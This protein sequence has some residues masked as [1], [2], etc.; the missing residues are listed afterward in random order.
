MAIVD[1]KYLK[2][3]FEFQ[4][5][6]KS[7]NTNNFME[8]YKEYLNFNKGDSVE[9]Y[10]MSGNR[11]YCPLKDTS[12]NKKVKNILIIVHELSRTGAP[13]VAL[14]TAKVLKTEGY[15][16][17][18]VTLKN[19]PLLNEFIDFGIPVIVMNELRY[20]QYTNNGL[21]HF[22]SKLDLDIF[23]ESFD[24]IIMITATLYN[25]VRHYMNKNKKIYW[26][27]HEGSESYTILNNKMPKNIPSNIKVLCGGDYSAIQL[28]KYNFKYYPRILNYGVFDEGVHK[29]LDN[30]S[31]VTFL[32]A[33][34]ISK[35]KGQLY[36]LNTI[37]K[38][39]REQLKK[40]EFIFI[41]DPYEGDID[42]IKI[43]DDI[44]NYINKHPEVNIKLY[45]SISRDDLFELYKKIDVLVLASIDDPMPVVA[46]ENLMLG[47]IVLCSTNTGTAYYLK[48][49]VNGFVFETGNVDSLTEK[50]I[51]IINNN[52]KLET[53][54][55]NG[56]E[57]FE[58]Y[59][60]MDVFKKNILKIINEE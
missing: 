2:T 23:I 9:L 12:V 48:D 11:L 51:Y 18:L 22:K 56:R 58:E 21:Y 6:F 17:T 10:K 47:N 8:T 34:T 16:V 39:S 38:L 55:K 41:G 52:D 35:R 54:R 32:M 1:E 27:I 29:Y 7:D 13:I 57:V 36:L 20:I 40:S 44:E 24:D 19:G 3:E 33:A 50:I 49:K 5:Y 46:T 43:K 26:W 45:K 15:F 53:I 37:K 42:G 31:K 59:F 4:N 60:D 14:D 25:L 28:K 30:T